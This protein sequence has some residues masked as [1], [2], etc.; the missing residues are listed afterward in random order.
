[1]KTL[2]TVLLMTTLLAAGGASAS[3]IYKWVDDDG[4]VHYGDRPT[5]AAVSSQQPVEQLALVSRRTDPERVAAGIEARVE[6]E[7]SR[8]QSRAAAEEA[9]QEAEQARADAAERAEKCATYRQRQQKFSESRRLYKVGPDGER[10]YLDE[11][12][13]AEA[14]Q[15]TA[16]QVAEFCSP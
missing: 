4:N 12:Q 14:R 2:P 1:M 9:E 3:G 6:R 15:R 10:E 11:S 8:E 5:A 7:A 13:M 16:D